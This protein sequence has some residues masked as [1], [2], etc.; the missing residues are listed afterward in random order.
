M[1]DPVQRIILVVKLFCFGCC[2]NLTMQPKDFH[3]FRMRVIAIVYQFGSGFDSAFKEFDDLVRRWLCRSTYMA[4][5]VCHH[6]Q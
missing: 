6:R 1:I 3:Q 4:I 5:Y 2:M